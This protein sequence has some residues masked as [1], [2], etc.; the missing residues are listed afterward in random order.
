LAGGALVILAAGALIW[1]LL[2]TLL[3]WFDHQTSDIRT[4]TIGAIAL[5][6][7]PIVTYLANR[8]IDQRRALDRALRL[9]KLEL[10]EK[11]FTMLMRQFEA[12]IPGKPKPDGEEVARFISDTKPALLTWGSNDVNKSWGLFWRDAGKPRTNWQ[13]MIALEDLIKVIRKDLGHSAYGLSPGDLGR[14]FLNDIDD[15]KPGGPKAHLDVAQTP[16]T[17][18]QNSSAS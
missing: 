8:A 9:H 16:V 10:Y 3:H 15:F 2:R 6:I 17:P 13:S 18:P 14:I 11:I 4:A 7:V 12:D 1:L 5:I